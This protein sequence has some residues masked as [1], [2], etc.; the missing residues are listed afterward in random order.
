M[1][2]LASCVQPRLWCVADDLLTTTTMSVVKGG[3]RS[4]WFSTTTR[5]VE[6]RKLSP[7]EFCIGQSV[8]EEVAAEQLWGLGVDPPPDAV[9]AYHQHKNGSTSAPYNFLATHSLLS[10]V[11]SGSLSWDDVM[12]GWPDDTTRLA[13]LDASST[14]RRGVRSFVDD[15]RVPVG[16][17]GHAKAAFQVLESV[18]AQEQYLYK[19]GKNHVVANG[20]YCRMPI[21][22]QGSM[23]E[24]KDD[25]VQLGCAVDTR[26]D[27]T[28]HLHHILSRGPRKLHQLL[29]EL[30]NLGLP[31]AAF[32]ASMQTRML[33]AA[34]F[35]L[36]LVVRVPGFEKKL[37]AMQAFWF[38][39]ALGCVS[40]P[41]V[42][43]MHEFGVR[44]RLSA[45]AWIRAISLRR[46]ASVELRYAQEDAIMIKA[47]EEPTS[48]SA[49][50]AAQVGLL[51]IPAVP[52]E[53][54]SGKNGVKLKL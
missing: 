22:L 15:T 52:A 8:L 31:F 46:R 53:L 54:R 3:A 27:G 45:L 32:R 12:K 43:L 34:A 48:W 1:V 9:A 35:G 47:E 36:E 18:A 2:K 16:S 49:A 13:L 40:V 50:V 4:K 23:V 25:A 20:F 17:H 19:P 42:V 10:L 41:R 30:V 11:Q 14:L 39:T 5:V 21:P 44:D 28:A 33:P 29:G 38:G 37:N 24:Y 51:Q 26:F 7:V 6:G